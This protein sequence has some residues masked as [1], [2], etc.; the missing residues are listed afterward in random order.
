M[1]F[2][3]WWPAFDWIGKSRQ[4]EQVCKATQTQ[5]K[6]EQHWQ[7]LITPQHRNIQISW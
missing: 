3:E 7:V 1:P 2:R 5:R 4:L 6:T